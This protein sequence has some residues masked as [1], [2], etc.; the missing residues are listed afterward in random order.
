[1]DVRSIRRSLYINGDTDKKITSPFPQHD[2][3]VR[4]AGRTKRSQDQDGFAVV[5]GGQETREGQLSILIDN[6]LRDIADLLH[7]LQ[8]LVAYKNPVLEGLNNAAVAAAGAYLAL[9]KMGDLRAAGFSAP[10]GMASSG[11]S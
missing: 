2:K 11:A 5:G 1:L 8:I 7:R 3:F 6:R 10:D 9:V 4:L